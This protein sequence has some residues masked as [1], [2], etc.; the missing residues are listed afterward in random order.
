MLEADFDAWPFPPTE[1]EAGATVRGFAMRLAKEL[2]W[3]AGGIP[4]PRFA[5]D[6]GSVALGPEALDVLFPVPARERDAVDDGRG[7]RVLDFDLSDDDAVPPVDPEDPEG[8]GMDE[9]PVV[10]LNWSNR[11]FISFTLVDDEPLGP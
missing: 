5:G 10:V 4:R 6:F 8:A 11:F 7:A 1:R 3:L 2:G 9:L